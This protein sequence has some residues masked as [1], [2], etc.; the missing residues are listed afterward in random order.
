MRSFVPIICFLFIWGTTLRANNQDLSL[1]IKHRNKVIS[2]ILAAQLRPEAEKIAQL[3]VLALSTAESK[4]GIQ[5]ID[6]AEVYFDASPLH[7][8]GITTVIPRDRIQI[9]T[10]APLLSS[11]VGKYDDYLLE[12]LT[13]EWAHLLSLQPR[14][15]AFRIASWLIGNT[16]R[17]NA[18][19]PR[20]THEGLAVW[21]ESALGA[22]PDS[23]WIETTRKKYAQNFQENGKHPL[24]TWDL[25]GHE[26]IHAPHS[27]VRAGE[28]PYSFGYALI[29]K[30]FQKAGGAQKFIEASSSSL[31]LSFRKTWQSLGV[32]VD[33]IFLE[34][35][36][37]WAAAPAQKLKVSPAIHTGNDLRGPFQSERGYTWINYQY[38][39]DTRESH[40][41]LTE[42]NELHEPIHQ[43]KWPFKLW[44]P[45]KAYRFD[46]NSW[47]VMVE[48]PDHWFEHNFSHA[49]SPT[50]RRLAIIPD[51]SVSV[52]NL[53]FLNT[54]ER[55][56]EFEFHKGQLI[57]IREGGDNKMQ[58]LS[59]TPQAEC[60]LENQTVLHTSTRAF[61]RLSS[62]SIQIRKDAPPEAV[63]SKHNGH[64]SYRDQLLSSSGKEFQ[65]NAQILPL[66][67][68]GYQLS[69]NGNF[70]TTQVYNKNYWGP[71]LLDLRNKKK[72]TAFKLPIRTEGA[73]AVFNPTQDQIIYKEL[74]WDKDEIR[75]VAIQ[76]LLKTKPIF[77]AQWVPSKSSIK[78]T[79]S[80][81]PQMS[82]E[83][84]QSDYSASSTLWPKFWIPSLISSNNALV[85]VGQTF[86]SDITSRWEGSSVLGYNSLTQ[87]PLA[88]TSLQ[89]HPPQAKRW[90]HPSLY[91]EY[92]P[93]DTSYLGFSDSKI[94]EQIA[95]AYT[96][97]WPFTLQA[98]W[99]G[100]I[101]TGVE[102]QYHS[103]IADFASTKDWIPSLQLRL[104][105]YGALHPYYAT[106]SLS[107]LQPFIYVTG[108][109]RYLKDP[110]LKASLFGLLK[111]STYSR[112]LLGIE[113]AATEISNFPSSYF[114]WGGLA[115]FTPASTHYFLNRGFPTSNFAAEDLVRLSGEWII[116][117]S[118]KPSSL[119]WNRVRVN[120]LDLRF[121]GE[122]ITW[123]SFFS[124]KFRVG[125]QY[126]SSLGFELDL[127]GSAMH[128]V[129]Y[130][131]SVG[132]FKGFGLRES[133]QVVTQL[134]TGLSL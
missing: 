110:E 118:K 43:F 127:G 53:C 134:R 93:I 74:L 85:V 92:S 32:D 68:G 73:E 121:I 24:E 91:V 60:G 106:A 50:R 81:P 122:S 88:T 124:P 26:D 97:T 59:A 25:D 130:R 104:G 20:W 58:V 36:D 78:T 54:G 82:L 111:S 13:H 79:K 17:P 45:L 90:G 22:R 108:Q 52:N 31:G 48:A 65:L 71:A 117:L 29:E 103:S 101:A 67:L 80:E 75:S 7:H 69:A 18:S 3:T 87:R 131:L 77:T 128:Y 72:I 38:F 11:S 99:T 96:H 56:R 125:H 61:E 116:S 120:S 84:T 105:S 5:L 126:A 112:V 107:E 55:L 19:W 33:Q 113:G 42:S 15:G 64:Q 10:S 66:S 27:R 51:D 133:F 95:T 114:V 41:V 86:Y 115:P 123:S 35:R 4:L 16:S 8:N 12:T 44:R 2:V 94:Q 34:L 9:Y 14:R 39:E 109:M 62:P 21:T 132:A 102:Y 70:A 57:W 129:N 30:L 46:E 76:E 47:L 83:V 49:R 23:G 40:S 89:W 119:S 1:E 37:E 6:N 98:K 100:A 63:F 28:I